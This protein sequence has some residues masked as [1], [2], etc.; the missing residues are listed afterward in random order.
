MSRSVMVMQI[1][2]RRARCGALVETRN[3]KFADGTTA[4][5]APCAAWEAISSN[6]TLV[7]DSCET[8]VLCPDCIEQLKEWL[9]EAP[10]DKKGQVDESAGEDSLERL[11]ADIVKA[12]T[13]GMRHGVCQQAIACEYFGHGNNI[14][15]Q[16]GSVCR[17]YGDG[18]GGSVSC[19]NAMLD[20]VLSRCKALGIDL[21]AG[22]Q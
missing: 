9:A 14:S 7:R 4:Y 17:G 22:E 18:T 11:A 1:L 3:T 5:Y 13:N 15:C 16:S 19:C 2:T 20:D 12:V 8:T 6:N 21:K 10:K